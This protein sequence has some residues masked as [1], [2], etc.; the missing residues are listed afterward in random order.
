MISPA[1]EFDA[2]QSSRS[3][4]VADYLSRMIETMQ[5]GE[6]IGTKDDLRQQLSVAMGTMNE[7]VRLLQERGLVT[8]K[9]G[10]KG[11]LFVASPNPL[12][13]IG[14]LIIAIRGEPSTVREAESIRNA[15]ELLVVL[16]AVRDRTRT[17]IAAMRK[18]IKEMTKNV[19]DPHAFLITNWDL[20]ARIAESGKERLL[21]SIYLLV[22]NVVRDQLKGVRPQPLLPQMSRERLRVHIDLV[23]S[24]INKDE[25]A[26]RLAVERHAQE[27]S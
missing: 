5:P 4:D 13:N 24:I 23:D 27:V 17:D 26:A 25:A 12:V 7:A 6:R 1:R 8:I 22:S 15:L 19:D 2:P 18:L 10:P 21:T 3:Q 9:S 14:Q 20:H 16:A 11:G